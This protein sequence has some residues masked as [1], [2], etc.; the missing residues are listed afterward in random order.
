MSRFNPCPRCHEYC[1][2]NACKCELFEVG[3]PFKGEVQ[4]WREIYSKEAECAAEKYADVSDAEGDY[5]IIRGSDAE[6]WVRDCSGTITKW[7]VSGESVP[8]YYAVEIKS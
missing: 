4:D 6:V 3:E 7:Q 8:K 2:D 5:T 1:W